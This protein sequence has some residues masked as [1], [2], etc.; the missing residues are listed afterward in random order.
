MRDLRRSASA[1]IDFAGRALFGSSAPRKTA[2]DLAIDWRVDAS[3]LVL[4][5]KDR[6][7]PWLADAPPAFQYAS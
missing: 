6:T 1:T 3:E 2:P 5:A 7:H 4:S